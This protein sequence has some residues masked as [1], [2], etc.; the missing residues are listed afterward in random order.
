MKRIVFVRP[1]GGV[2]ILIPAA[3]DRL[4]SAV[5]IAGKS[6]ALAAPEPVGNLRA[7]ARAAGQT[8]EVLAGEDE[9][10]QIDRICKAAVP[11]GCTVVAVLDA[12]AIPDDRTHRDAWV[13][14]GERIVVDPGRVKSHPPPEEAV[15]AGGV[16][17]ADPRVDTLRREIASDTLSVVEAV[18]AEMK[19]WHLRTQLAVNAL[20]EDEEVASAKLRAV[21]EDA[22]RRL[23]AEGAPAGKTW[24]QVAEE[25][26]AERN[27]EVD[28]LV[29]TA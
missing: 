22:R 26:V 24:R 28:T 8:L 2:G 21:R 14:D 18:V 4:V 6:I 16:V 1:D 29:G 7:A 17:M 3:D 20:K 23:A 27:A 13:W 15:P 12:D 9:A 25:I 19:R 5:R 10:A 11:P